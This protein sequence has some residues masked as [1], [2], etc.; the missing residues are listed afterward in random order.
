MTSRPA[1]GLADTSLFIVREQGRALRGEPPE[2]IAV[3][4]VSI[5]ELTLGVLAAA[6]ST[7]ARRLETLRRAEGPGP[8]ADH[9]PGGFRMGGATALPARRWAADAAQ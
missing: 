7:R 1:L 8:T 9:P 6:S 4:V 2:R 5:G 3:S